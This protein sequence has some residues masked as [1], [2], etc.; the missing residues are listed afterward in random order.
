[1]CG[2]AVVGAA[3]CDDV[4]CP[5]HWQTVCAQEFAASLKLKPDKILAELRQLAAQARPM[6]A[7]CSRSGDSSS[8]DGGGSSSGGGGGSSSSNLDGVLELPPDAL[9]RAHMLLTVAQCKFKTYDQVM[10][11]DVR[12]RKRTGSARI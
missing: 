12:A 2:T 11:V 3:H 10:S 6:A 1:M 8:S 5:A 7:S 4:V 9:C